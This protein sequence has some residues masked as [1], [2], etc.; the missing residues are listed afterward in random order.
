M[1]TTP[2]NK[3]IL[4]ILA[5]IHRAIWKL[6]IIVWFGILLDAASWPNE[7]HLGHLLTLL[8]FPFPYLLLE[9]V[10]IV[11]EYRHPNS[12]KL[13]MSDPKIA[14]FAF[15]YI[16]LIETILWT[17][18]NWHRLN[19]WPWLLLVLSTTLAAYLIRPKLARPPRK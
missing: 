12:G 6:G 17:L 8:I 13:G 11:S 15:T 7:R 14:R 19:E 5:T 16:A 3:P 2:S 9:A 4:K 18:A 10:H 1:A